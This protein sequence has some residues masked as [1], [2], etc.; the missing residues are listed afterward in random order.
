MTKEE[1]ELLC[2]V[3]RGV[4]RLLFS[5]AARQYAGGHVET[6]GQTDQIAIEVWLKLED[7]R[8]APK[9]EKQRRAVK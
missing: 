2:A 8:A 5:L 7:V 1:R 9:A 4:A 3:A 6:G